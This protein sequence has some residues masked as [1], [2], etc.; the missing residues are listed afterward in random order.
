MLVRTDY[1]SRN[2]MRRYTL[3]VLLIFIA[4]TPVYGKEYQSSFGFTVDIPEHWLVLTRKELKENPDLFDFSQESFG[5]VDKDLLKNIQSK[6]K[7]GQVEYYLN[8]KT[9]D[10]SF[11]DNINVIKEIGKIP[12][13]NTQLREVCNSA[14]KQFS[15]Y[16]GRQIKVY[17]CKLVDINNLKSL[18]LEFDGVVEETRSIQYTIQKSPS[19]QIMITATCKN[20]VLDTIRKEF[21]RIVLSVKM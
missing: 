15:S 5:N 16:F 1:T 4:I 13:N 6:V 14:P 3:V 18:F 8:Q 21:N 11:A 2:A 7:S 20:S 10:S 12:E 9:S 17:Q 19:V